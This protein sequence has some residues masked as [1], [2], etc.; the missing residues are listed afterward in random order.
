MNRF[1]LISSLL[2]IL[3]LQ[4]FV[5]NNINM[6]GF[7][8]PYIYV[9]FVFIFPLIKNRSIILLAAFMFGILLDFFSDTGGIHAFSLVFACY[10]RLFFIKV[11]FR[12]TE[13]DFLLFDLKQESFGKVFNY[14]LTLTIIHH[15]VMFLFANFS[16]TNIIDVLLNT[17]YSSIFT[18]TL[19]FLGSFLFRKKVASF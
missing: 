6:F 2:F 11:F 9:S 8:N 14:V 17:V 12:K 15:F 18:V 19:Y 7:V 1:Y 16:F 10:L 3:L 5:C 13:I 4:V